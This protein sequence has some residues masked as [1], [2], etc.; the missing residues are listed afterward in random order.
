MSDILNHLDTKIGFPSYI[1]SLNPTLTP[2]RVPNIWATYYISRIGSNSRLVD[3]WGRSV[4]SL[5][6][7]TDAILSKAKT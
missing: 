1:P 7:S 5:I 2:Y 3:A 6:S 4:N